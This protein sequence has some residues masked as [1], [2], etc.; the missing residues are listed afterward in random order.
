MKIP[1]VHRLKGFDSNRYVNRDA[2]YANDSNCDE[3]QIES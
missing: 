2:Q 3:E 1:I